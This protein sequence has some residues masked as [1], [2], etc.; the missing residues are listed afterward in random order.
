MLDEVEE[1]VYYQ[2]KYFDSMFYVSSVLCTDG[3]CPSVHLLL[4]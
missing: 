2:H 1:S 3:A 4:H